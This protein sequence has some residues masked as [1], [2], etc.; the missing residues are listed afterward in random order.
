MVDRDALLHRAVALRHAGQ[1]REASA[2]LSELAAHF[3]AF[4]RLHQERAQCLVV[5]G[6]GP[7]A[8]AALEEALQRNQALPACWD[9]LAQLRRLEG[10]A[11]GAGQAQARLG[12]L[13][14]LPREVVMANALHADG[15]VGPAAQVLRDY[16][17]RDEA[18][19]G[20]AHLLARV[21]M[22]HRAPAADGS[23]DH[24]LEAERV[25][26]ALVARAPDYHAA[27][28]D[29]SVLL[30]RLQ[31]P[32]E[33]RAHAEL[34]LRHDPANRGWRKQF[35]AACIVLG[36]HAPVIAIYADLLADLPA[37]GHETAELRLFR[38]NALKTE[39]R[40][41]E[42]IADYHAALAARPGY[43][44]AWFSLANLKTYRFTA[45]ETARM[46]QALAD[47]ATPAGDRIYLGFALAKA[48]EDAAEHEAA[49]AHLC[50]ANGLRRATS[51]YQ[52]AI[53]Q[54][55]A[56]QIAAAQDAPLFAAR[57]GFGHHDPAPIFI[58]GLP[59]SGS[60]LLEQILASHPDVEGTMELTALGK[61][62][63]QLCG[64]DDACGLPADPAALAR[65]PH[66]EAARLGETYLAQARVHRQLGRPFFVDKMPDNFWHV[67]LIHLIL[68]RATII[69]MRRE[70]VSCGLA[71]FRQL[72]GSANQ[73]FSY[74]LED[75]GAHTRAY[76]AM[77][78]HWDS[79]LPSKVLRVHYE[80]L[81]DDLAGQVQRVLAHCRLP[82]D[83]ACM[84]FHATARSVR[85][86]SAEQVRQPMNRAGVDRWQAYSAHLGPLR[87]A[88]GD[89]STRYRN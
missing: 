52:P 11:A 88:L 16:L 79:A 8:M 42:A 34:L 49:W 63:A 36:D 26:R 45:D 70:P 28:F 83:P 20:A 44:V 35:A 65:L 57:R 19:Q 59:R 48:A 33:A 22:D 43:G 21:L 82:F 89:A 41:A 78:R 13:Q 1:P 46:G 32:A 38:G 75:I 27:R 40:V 84:A 64:R 17:R 37:L 9:M 6:D 58:I 23:T 10:D 18:N 14:Q 71:N 4:S 47:P 67:G 25:L 81:V 73:E 5:L 76:L 80:D 60:T 68:P 30:L 55:S 62:A 87:A 24:L 54:R 3:P 85:T 50:A 51:R 29:L 72:F 12:L 15:D 53:A 2:V 66:N 7:G 69:D 61:L 74:S 77:M 86:P 56:A 39:G 31:A